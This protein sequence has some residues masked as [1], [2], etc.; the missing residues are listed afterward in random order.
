MAGDRIF[1]G[2]VRRREWDRGLIL[3]GGEYRVLRYPSR[4]LFSSFVSLSSTKREPFIQKLVLEKGLKI[5]EP[6][7]SLSRY[8][9]TFVMPTFFCSLWHPSPISFNFQKRN[10]MDLSLGV[11]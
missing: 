7:L 5:K 10:S 6:Y 9:H 11:A 4:I 1:Y 8:A 3:G 2:G